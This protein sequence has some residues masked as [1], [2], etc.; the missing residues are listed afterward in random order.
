MTMLRPEHTKSGRLQF[1]LTELLQTRKSA[2]NASVS[3]CSP[4]YLRAQAFCG[5][6]GVA[7][8]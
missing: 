5:A 8:N 6:V 4:I 2:E 1:S 7:R 3:G